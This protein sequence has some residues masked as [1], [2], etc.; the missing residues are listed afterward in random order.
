MICGTLWTSCWRGSRAWRLNWRSVAATRAD[1]GVNR[2][3]AG[4]KAFANLKSVIRTCQ[5]AGRNFLNYGMSVLQADVTDANG[6]RC[7]AIVREWSPVV[8]FRAVG[9]GS[10]RQMTLEL[11]TAA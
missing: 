11:R 5:K 4:A 6:L 9:I 3:A 8:T 7:P 10:P 2:T 1:G